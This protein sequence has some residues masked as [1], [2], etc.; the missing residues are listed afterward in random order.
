MAIKIKQGDVTRDTKNI[1]IVIDG[2]KRSI[3]KVYN[4]TRLVWSLAS[5]QLKG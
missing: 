3:Q 1:Y 4:G 2:I 5:D